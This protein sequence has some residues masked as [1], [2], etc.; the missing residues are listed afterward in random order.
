NHVVAHGELIPF[1]RQ[2]VGQI[3]DAPAVAD[4]LSLYDQGLDLGLNAALA[5]ETRHIAAASWDAGAFK[6]AGRAAAAR[7][8]NPSRV[9]IGVKDEQPR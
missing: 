9:D 6:A 5:L 8:R 1:T 7:Q 4:V 2:L 3:A